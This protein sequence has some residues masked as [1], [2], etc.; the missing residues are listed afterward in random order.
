M[1]ERI[2]KNRKFKKTEICEQI[3][4][5]KQNKK[6]MCSNTYTRNSLKEM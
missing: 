4:K 2:S 1:C 3:S 6:K 5:Q